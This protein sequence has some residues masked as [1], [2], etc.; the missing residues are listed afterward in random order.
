MLFFII[1]ISLQ[2]DVDDK[3]PGSPSSP[4]SEITQLKDQLEAQAL[5]TRQALGQLMLVREQLISLLAVRCGRQVTWL[6]LLSAF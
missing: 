5:Q 1:S 3:S 4:R 6:T 2:C